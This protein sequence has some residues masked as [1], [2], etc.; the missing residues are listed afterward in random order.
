MES[1]EIFD[2]DYMRALY[3]YAYELAAAGYQWEKVP[4]GLGEE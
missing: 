2:R 4:P 3:Q 1:G